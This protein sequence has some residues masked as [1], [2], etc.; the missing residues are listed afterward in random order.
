MNEKQVLEY[1]CPKCGAKQYNISEMWT[2]GNKWET[3][4]QY[5]YRKF[6]SITCKK[7]LYTEIF[8]VPMKMIREVY[9]SPI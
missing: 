5:H 3:I 6:T 2:F 7:C 4:F 8:K 1:T 9:N